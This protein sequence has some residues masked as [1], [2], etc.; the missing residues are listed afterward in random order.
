MARAPARFTLLFDVVDLAACGHFAVAAY[1]AAASESCEPQKPDETHTVLMLH[2]EVANGVPLRQE[3]AIA[4]F[5]SI[6]ARG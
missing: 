4:V 6:L 1:D 5:L 2:G 3:L